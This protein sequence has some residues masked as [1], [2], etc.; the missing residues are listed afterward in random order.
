MDGLYGDLCFLY[1]VFLRMMNSLMLSSERSFVSRLFACSVQKLIVGQFI[2]IS[3]FLYGVCLLL[4]SDKVLN[5]CFH[6]EH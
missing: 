6:G 2:Q 5:F 1:G 3:S 4:A